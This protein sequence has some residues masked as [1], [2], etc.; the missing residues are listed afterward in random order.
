MKS[1]ITKS[2]SSDSSQPVTKTAVYLSDD[3]FGEE[4]AEA[5]RTVLWDLIKRGPQ[6]PQFLI[7]DGAAGLEKAIDAVWDGDRTQAHEP[8]GARARAHARGGD[9]RLDRHDLATTPKD[10][11]TRHEAFIR[12]WRLD[13][14]VADCLE[15]WRKP[16]IVSSPSWARR[17]ASGVAREQ[18]TRSSVCTKTSSGG[19]TRGLCCRRPI[20]CDIVLLDVARLRSDQHA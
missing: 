2:D 8:T 18:R 14:P 19:L 3:W 10:I 5:G 12:K 15:V 1:I 11:G 6:R 16:V 17:R 13:R 20:L 9:R 7:V 4:S